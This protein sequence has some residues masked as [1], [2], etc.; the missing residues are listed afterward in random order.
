MPARPLSGAG[1]LRQQLGGCSL[2]LPSLENRPS[3]VGAG[4]GIA[5]AALP[6]AHEA[7][8]LL[9]VARIRTHYVLCVS[10]VPAPTD[11]DG[12]WARWVSFP[13]DVAVRHMV[14]L[15]RL[16]LP[17][18]VADTPEDT[19]D[20]PTGKQPGSDRSVFGFWWTRWSR[21]ARPRGNRP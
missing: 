21:E 11:A 1:D 7:S 8:D 9:R 15:P 19:V 10:P 14:W 3:A 2:G 17:P 13:G 5:G 6:R 4:L 16:G 12:N 18:E 20:Q